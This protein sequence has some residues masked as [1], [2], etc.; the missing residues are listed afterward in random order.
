MGKISMDE[1]KEALFK[2]D[3][4]VFSQPE[5]TTNNSVLTEDDI[6]KLCDAF[7]Y[8]DNAPKISDDFPV[9]TEN[10]AKLLIRRFKKFRKVNRQLGVQARKILHPASSRNPIKSKDILKILNN[11]NKRK[12]GRG[13]NVGGAD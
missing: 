13:K 11:I 9:M 5:N 4:I 1:L 2:S 6:L 3:K 8:A 7:E 12:D 10:G